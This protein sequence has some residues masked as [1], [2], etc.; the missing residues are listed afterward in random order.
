MRQVGRRSA[1]L[2]C[3]EC[4]QTFTKIFKTFLTFRHFVEKYVKLEEDLLWFAGVNAN[5]LSRNF[6][7]NLTF[8]YFSNQ[9]VIRV[10]LTLNWK[11][12]SPNCC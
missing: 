1:L 5:K 9:N 6:L 11:K 8:G 7:M 12:L 3:N 4:K 2:S 10:F